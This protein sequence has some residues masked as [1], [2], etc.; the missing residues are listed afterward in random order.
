MSP[1]GTVWVWQ[2]DYPTNSCVVSIV[3]FVGQWRTKRKKNYGNGAKDM[4]WCIVCFSGYTCTS[5]YRK[6]ITVET[7]RLIFNSFECLKFT[8]RLTLL[9]ALLLTLLTT[10]FR[11]S[12]CKYTPSDIKIVLDKIKQLLGKL[13][14]YKNYLW[15]FKFN[16][17][18][19]WYTDA[20]GKKS[21]MAIFFN[22]DHVNVI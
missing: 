8:L 21:K 18:R 9:T 4:M 17:M 15:K 16:R 10:Y 2:C 7:Y 19:L 11:F 22:K 20:H 6:I 3:K 12:G 13:I 5:I 14:M 1:N